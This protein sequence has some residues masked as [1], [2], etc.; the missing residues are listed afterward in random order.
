MPPVIECRNLTHHFGSKPALRDVSWQV[1][2]RRIC[3]SLGRNP[4][5]K[6]TTINILSSLIKPNG[7]CGLLFGE[8]SH[9]LS[10]VTKFSIGY[11]IEGHIQY[12]FVSVAQSTS[13]QC[14]MQDWRCQR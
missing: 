11:E 8:D 1:L 3:G 9:Q 6:T 14:S 5:G 10:A 13:C 12:V 7:G 2:P 4:A